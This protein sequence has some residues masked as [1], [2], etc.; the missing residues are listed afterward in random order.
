VQFA[1]QGQDLMHKYP[2]SESPAFS[3]D[4]I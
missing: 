2:E 1:V 4:A 3:V